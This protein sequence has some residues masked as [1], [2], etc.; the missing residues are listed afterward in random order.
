MLQRTLEIYNDFFIVIILCI[1]IVMIGKWFILKNQK[2]KKENEKWYSYNTVLKNEITQ[3]MVQAIILI[4]LI[5]FL[6]EAFNIDVLYL[7]QFNRFWK[8]FIGIWIV[9]HI[10][11][12]KSLYNRLVFHDFLDNVRYGKYPYTSPENIYLNNL[13]EYQ[14]NYELEFEKLGILK[15]LAP[16]SLI[17]LLAGYILEG[18]SI[19]VSWNWYTVAFF[20]ILFLYFYKLWKV[21]EYLKI[22]KWKKL[23]TQK[24]LRI[25]QY[26]EKENK[27]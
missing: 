2:D 25:L 20:S 4:F 13:D 26:K 7:V 6:K 27:E 17:P 8:L 21:Y 3:L 9:F 24:E 10:K 18:K 14:I 5:I 23:Q 11:S 1:I 15:S 16:V 22:W 19:A 12:S